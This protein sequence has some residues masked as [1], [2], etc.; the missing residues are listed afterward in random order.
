MSEARRGSSAERDY[1]SASFVRDIAVAVASSGVEVAEL[2]TSAGLTISD[3]ADLDAVVPGRAAERLWAAAV[4][5]T[6]D[7]HLGLALGRAAKL[8]SL[9][10][11]G[12]VLRHSPHFRG[13]IER[14]SN[15]ARLLISAVSFE[16]EAESRTTS[17]IRIVVEP[18]DHYVR[19][20]PR[21]PIEC[22]AASVVALGRQLVGRELPIERVDFRHDEPPSSEAYRT[23]FDGPVRFGRADDRVV[24][25]TDV[26]DLP[27]LLAHAPSLEAAEKR[28]TDRLHA[29]GSPLTVVDAARRAIAALSR[30]HAPTIEETAEKLATSVRSLQRALFESGTTFRR[31]GDEVRREL[32]LEHLETRDTTV[33]Q[34]ALLLGFSDA[35]S[36][37]RTFKRWTGRTPRGRAE[38]G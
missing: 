5:A 12:Q 20:A 11:L 34:V 36:F 17:A 37:H 25:P 8:D 38:P 26:L 6:G 19:R 30:G 24:V 18:H 16:I 27:V 1:V 13:A 7:P 23:T 22:T 29:R 31:L 10:L 33:A 14:L 2:L 4:R 28:V 3:L 35:R 9:G 32:A 15:H 21:Q